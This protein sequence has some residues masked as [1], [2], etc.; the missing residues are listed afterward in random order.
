[1]RAVPDA[2]RRL[3][4]AAA[5]AALTTMV[6]PAG[7]ADAQQIDSVGCAS[8]LGAGQ[9]LAAAVAA[10]LPA[11]TRAD[12]AAVKC[13]GARSQQAA[14][15]AQDR[16]FSVPESPAFTFLNTSPAE[17]TRPST[18]REFGAAVLSGVD[19]NG[20]PVQGFALEFSPFPVIPGFS[21]PLR[22]YQRNF[23]DRVSYRTQ[24]SFGAVRAGGDDASTD[25]ALG[26]RSTLFDDADPMQSSRFT[27]SLASSM[28]K[29]IPD[30][31]GQD[32]TVALS[33][34]E[35]A[36]AA[37]RTQWTDRWNG[38]RLVVA[39]AFGQRFVNSDPKDRQGL[40]W[41]AWA[42]G[43][44][45][46]GEWGVL[47]GYLQLGRR[48]QVPGSPSFSSLRFGGRVV[49]GSGGINGFL[50]A[51]GESRFNASAAADDAGTSWSAGLEVRATDGVWISTGFGQRNAAAAAP[52]RLM[53]I[54]N[55]RIGISKAPRFSDL[56][57]NQFE[58]E[59]DDGE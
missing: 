9:V 38:R 13:S 14:D 3:A 10:S 18:P 34:I 4:V 49:V 7:S 16:T 54:A 50:E 30:E 46:L 44:N 29:C 55:L 17:I 51:I 53:L 12:S 35:E 19:E 21:V 36:I 52:D 32:S 48:Y 8:E 15:E 56:Q 28:M 23:L 39:V 37:T 11:A 25:L 45:P 24:I 1:M 43:S 40:G 42:L 59:S 6:A 57:R 58:V 26:V 31:P 41:S 47:L 33:C 20:R 27:D 5:A 22:S 2:A